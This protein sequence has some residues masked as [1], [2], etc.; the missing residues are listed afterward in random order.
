MSV[1]NHQAV[2]ETP[3][4]ANTKIQRA[5]SCGEAA[6]ISGK[7]GSCASA[8]KLGIQSKMTISAPGDRYEQEA[9]RIADQVVSSEI[10]P[11][12]ASPLRSSLSI[13]PLVQRQNDAEEEEEEMLQ[14]KSTS[15]AAGQSTAGQST[16]GQATATQ[17]AVRA[18]ASGGR[19][20]S[21]SDR[22]YFEP[23]FG[24]DLTHV[25]LHT[26]GE[27]Q[28]AARGINAR[29]Y[30]LGNHIAFAPGQYEP[31]TPRGRH[32]LAHELTHTFQQNGGRTIRR[33]C[34]SDPAK[35]PTGTKEDFEKKADEALNHAV[36][37]RKLDWRAK[38]YTRHIIDGARNSACPMYYIDKLLLM[39]NTPMASGDK[40][41]DENRDMT[42]KAEK[43]EETRL[44]DPTAGKLSGVEEDIADRSEPNFVS[45]KGEG[46]KE[47]QVDRTDP[48]NIVVRMKV[49]LKPKGKG[50]EDD[51]KRT[52]AIVDAIEKASSTRGYT[53]DIDFVKKNGAQDIFTVGVDPSQWTNSGNWVGD[54]Q[55][56]AH[57][58]HHLL[59]L[60]DRYNYI[61]GHAA[62][63][64]MVFKDRLFWFREQMGRDF[65]PLAD[66]S[67]MKDE[68]SAASMNDQDICALA[69][70][71]FDTCINARLDDLPVMQIEGRAKA[72]L[73]PYI[74]QNAGM[75]ERLRE[76][77]DRKPAKDRA[78]NCDQ[79]DPL[80]GSPPKSVFGDAKTI[81]ADADKFP[82]TNPHK[83]PKGED[84]KRKR[85]W[86]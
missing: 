79:T 73:T 35:I 77:W 29:A 17:S 40:L 67:M 50:T 28:S 65:D 64:N 27:A 60:E 18:V 8:E 32:L 70:G 39:F 19:P 36:Y 58:A 66:Q 45:R 38:G 57:E 84:L 20:L 42:E 74:P 71:D 81:E 2:T 76:S 4:V 33:T 7:C 1:Q 55:T 5:C 59:G 69:G 83:Q 14:A 34:P 12:Q 80:C 16:T 15:P 72:L 23:R 31:E 61:E 62:N 6:G 37:L 46:G 86:Q 26:G 54:P 10:A 41:A 11:G 47:F 53:L 22:S 43:K 48:T 21:R 63:E 82:L 9:D 85:K 44:A 30:T 52:K 51:V 68:H 24:H 75:I 49:L 13:S 3:T 56:I 25:R 78:R